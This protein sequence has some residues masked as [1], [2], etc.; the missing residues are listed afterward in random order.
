M[1]Y[2]RNPIPIGA[3][4]EGF[5]D[6]ELVEFMKQL[7]EDRRDKGIAIPRFVKAINARANK[8]GRS[9]TLA[10]YK[11]AEKFPAKG[12]PLIHEYLFVFAYE[13]LN[14]TRVGNSPQ[15]IATAHAMEVIGDAR[16]K[17]DIDYE[18]FAE[19]LSRK[20]GIQ[21]TGAEY[22][23][24]EQGMTKIVPHDWIWAASKILDLDPADLYSP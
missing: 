13:V 11:A 2:Y 15:S 12:I 4:P 24:A 10:E 22:R 23:T 16:V 1:T 19:R 6:I 17:A 14:A 5:T 21:V 20:L 18:T 3:A 9:F 7:A 8:S